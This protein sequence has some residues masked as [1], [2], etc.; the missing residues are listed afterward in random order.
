[1]IF[2]ILDFIAKNC[3]THNC[4]LY[5]LSRYKCVMLYLSI[6]YIICCI[7]GLDLAQRMEIQR[8]V[9][10]NGGVYS[11]DLMMETYVL[12][13]SCHKIN[14]PQSIASVIYDN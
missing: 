4:K 1:M 8:L 11:G 7:K 14:W 6:C 2:L 10:E 3:P 12:N 13:Y 5:I 9:I